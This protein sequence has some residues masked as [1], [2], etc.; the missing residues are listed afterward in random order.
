MFMGNRMTPTN[1][2]LRLLR[3]SGYV[4]CVIERWLP[5]VDL[6]KDAFGFADILA[7]HPGQR[8]VMLVQTTSLANVG[9]RVR[10]A[11]AI[12]E[13]SAAPPRQSHESKSSATRSKR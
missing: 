1:L 13:A 12:P 8:R 2:T 5:K 9:A 6:R 4:A 11:Q 7:A 10:K 3:K